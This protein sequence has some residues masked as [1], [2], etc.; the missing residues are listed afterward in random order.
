MKRRAPPASA[1][2]AAK[3]PMPKV[4]F[5][6]DAQVA[7]HTEA[8]AYILPLESKYDDFGHYILCR[9]GLPVSGMPI[10]WFAARCAVQGEASTFAFIQT[11]LEGSC[12]AYFAD[13]LG[14]PFRTLLSDAKSYGLIRRMFGVERG[15]ALL[16]AL[17]DIALQ[18]G[19]S[20]TPWPDF[21]KDPV[22]THA[23]IRSSECYFAFRKG[24]RMLRG[25]RD[26][27]TDA[28]SAFAVEL[29]G[30]GPK[31]TF[32][33]EFDRENLLRGR[34]AVIIGENGCGKT[35]A[36]AKIAKAM[37]DKASKVGVIHDKPEIN[38]V[39]AFIHT[40]STRDFAPSSAQG[41]ATARVFRFNPATPS[42]PKE[43]PL[44]SL[45]VDV[46]RGH[47][48]QGAL[49]DHFAEI[50]KDAFRG[51]QL[52]IPVIAQPTEHLTQEHMRN[53]RFEQWAQ[54]S[55]AQRL[56]NASMVYAGAPLMFRD[57][58]DNIRPLSLGQQSFL[59]FILTALANAGPGSL[60]VID[61]P[62]NFLHPNLISRFMRSLNKILCGTRSIALVATHS[63]FVVRE[64][65]RAQVHVMRPMNGTTAVVKPRMQTL[66]ANVASISNEVFGDDLPNH[67]YED[68]LDLARGQVNSF[69]EVLER[70]ASE[71]SVEAMLSLRRKMEG[72]DAQD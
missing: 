9:I 53:V 5:V 66:G 65:Q 62:E 11:L 27:D 61:E 15:R 72:N 52:F 68:L 14:K 54:G 21:K 10:N 23:M 2:P 46:A 13:Q 25:Q 28:C 32:N 18:P 49:L 30:K 31:A 55:E 41:S 47:D 1:A 44:T 6:L 16:S 34:I 26:N 7:E 42:K 35:S 64:V 39:L 57:G 48:N 12:T 58:Q 17:Q 8:D 51:L 67:L 37:V 20:Y 60:F 63:P 59:R 36:L 71:L 45:L 29:L 38:Q 69:E 33:F 24:E 70:F 19:A 22:F 3:K 4:A 40:A 43:A 56:H 50:L